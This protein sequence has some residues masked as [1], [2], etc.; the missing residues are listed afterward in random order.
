MSIWASESVAGEDG[1]D[2]FDDTVVSYISG[3]SNHYPGHFVKPDDPGLNEYGFAKD[4]T[5]ETPASVGTAW[6]PPWCVPGHDDTDED[7][8]C[9]VGPWLRLDVTMRQVSI[10]AGVEISNQNVYSV[11]LDESAVRKLRDNLT[12]WLANDKAY[13][14][15]VQK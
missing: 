1:N 15:E 14:R 9:V 6:I 3:W 13:P 7:V 11:C 4:I 8:D 12:D 10:W 5:E 2:R